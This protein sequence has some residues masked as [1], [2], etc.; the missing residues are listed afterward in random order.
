MKVFQSVIG[1]P[2]SVIM[3]FTCLLITLN[4]QLN[5]QT[6]PPP[7]M[8]YQAVLYDVNNPNPNTPY[9]LQSFPAYV[10][11]NDELGNLL[12]R[13]EHFSSTDA[14]GQVTI[15]IGDGLYM[16]G[17]ITNFN[18]INWASGKYYLVVEFDINGT[19]SAT[20]PEQ[21]VTVPYAFYAG[22]GLSSITS[23]GDQT[24]TITYSNG[25][26]YTS[27]TLNGFQGP[28]GVGIDTIY[29]VNNDI[30]INLSN[31]TSYSFPMPLSQVGNNTP[32]GIG[33]Y[34]QG[35]IV[36]YILRPG[37]PGYDPNQ[38]H[39]IITT[40]GH[41]TS[42]PFGCN[43]TLINGAD[44]PLIGQG[45]QNTLDI[46]S[47]CSATNTAAYY[48]YNLTYGG[49][50]DWVLPSKEEVREIMQVGPQNVY[51]AVDYATSTETG[52]TG[53]YKVTNTGSALA[54]SNYKLNS[55]AVLPIR[56]F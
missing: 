54:G 27:P 40:P 18:Q 52:A 4:F 46:I 49:Y 23:N 48:C 12:Y 19:I 13:E 8:N 24:L 41:M 30:F 45:G 56:Y 50:T 51:T 5:A 10:N 22:N 14:N 55:Y 21:L 1:I 53:C 9:S 33:D 37:D 29:V 28:T 2:L 25:S 31:G 17:P 26:T 36:G 7:Y 42:L 16:T 43:G 44:S 38:L 47:G 32:V 6:I 3:F 15:K 34:F 11:I 35:G 39:G 20:A